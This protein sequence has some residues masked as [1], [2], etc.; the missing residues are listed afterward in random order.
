MTIVNENKSQHNISAGKVLATA[1]LSCLPII[2]TTGDLLDRTIKNHKVD[3]TPVKDC[4]VKAV[5]Q[6]GEKAQALFS[7]LK[8]FS[9]LKVGIASVALWTIIDVSFTYW[10]VD[11]IAE[12]LKKK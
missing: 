11:K 3:K 1:G 9:A 7:S 10:L 5:K 4:F 12:K 6:S 8:K 2:S